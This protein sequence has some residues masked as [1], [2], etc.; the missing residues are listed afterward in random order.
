MEILQ[1]G[2]IIPERILSQRL[3]AVNGITAAATGS[4]TEV[5]DDSSA[6]KVLVKWAGKEHAKLTWET[7]ARL[8][9]H[10]VLLD[11]QARQVSNRMHLLLC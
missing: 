9:E 2:C 3:S 10:G 11:W 1:P 5:A 6:S 4:A 8:A 7:A